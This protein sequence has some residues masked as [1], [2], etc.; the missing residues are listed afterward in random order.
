MTK[1]ERFEGCILAGAIGDAYGSAYENQPE[2]LEDEST[3]Y[4]FGKPEKPEPIWQITDDTQL[5]LASIEALTENSQAGVS[6]IAHQFLKYY[7]KRKLKGLGASTLKALQELDFGAHWSQVGRTGEYA[8]GNGAAMRI[9]PLAFLENIS[10]AQIRDIC[11]LTHKN[12]EAYVGALVVIIAIQEILKENWNGENNL[13]SFIIPKLPDTSVRDRLIAIQG[14]QNLKEVGNFGNSGFVVD[15]VPLALA[16]ANQVLE[17]GLEQM[18]W[19]LIEIGGDTDTNCSIAGQIAG[20]L[21]GKTGIP[22]ELLQKLSELEDYSWIE[23][24]ILNFT[25]KLSC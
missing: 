18:Y 20:T 16:A 21:L 23:S 12:E 8:A 7:Q 6:L 3:F 11:F 13:L 9:A 10:K 5:T 24:S 19:E 22:K 14:I 17:I 2:R 15:S 25:Q 1:A 4:L